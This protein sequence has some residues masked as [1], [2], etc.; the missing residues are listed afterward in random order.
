MRFYLIFCRYRLDTGLTLWQHCL[1]RPVRLR[2]L[3]R[4]YARATA[5]CK[6]LSGCC[7]NRFGKSRRRSVSS[8]A[9]RTGSGPLLCSLQVLAYRSS[10]LDTDTFPA[11][12]WRSSSGSYYSSNC[13]KSSVKGSVQVHRSG[14]TCRLFLT[15]GSAHRWLYLSLG[16]EY[17]FRDSGGCHAFTRFSIFYAGCCSR[18][19]WPASADR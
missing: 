1:T 17:K 10:V 5:R 15:H 9:S 18:F 13:T 4:R 16:P 12:S 7:S 2:R 8:P 6:A 11:S 19:G 3:V 14:C